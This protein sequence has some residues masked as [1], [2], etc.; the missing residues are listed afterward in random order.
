MFI[1]R[2]L[3]SLTLLFSLAS[4]LLSS[5]DGNIGEVDAEVIDRGVWRVES[6]AGTKDWRGGHTCAP[7]PVW[8]ESENC[9]FFQWKYLYPVKI[10]TDTVTQFV[11]ATS[12]PIRKW[13]LLCW[14]C[15][16]E[17]FQSDWGKSVIE[18]FYTKNN[19]QKLV[20]NKCIYI[21]LIPLIFAEM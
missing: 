19:L 13:T 7:V 15:F 17:S 20:M 18:T 2:C 1:P 9:L 11:N 16:N 14:F 10:S 12:K 3:F 8:W 5:P 6:A 21:F 4:H